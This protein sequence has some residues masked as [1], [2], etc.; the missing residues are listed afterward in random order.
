MGW[1]I[2]H[3]NMFIVFARLLYCFDFFEDPVC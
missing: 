2:A 1:N 3:R